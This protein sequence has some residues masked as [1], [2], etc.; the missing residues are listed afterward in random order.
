MSRI[1]ADRVKSNNLKAEASRARRAADQHRVYSK[2][3][4]SVGSS[5]LQDAHERLARDYDHL[6]ACLME[7][8]EYFAEP[9]M[10][11]YFLA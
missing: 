2:Q 10:G 7:R 8:A 3:A 4:L 6:A 9:A 1:H 11:A 5:P